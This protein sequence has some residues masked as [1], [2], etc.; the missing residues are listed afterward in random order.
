MRRGDFAEA[1][2]IGDRVQRDWLASG[3]SRTHWPR[4]LQPVWRGDALAGRRVLVRCYHGLGDTLQFIRFAR[5]LRA[6]A[7]HVTVWAQP[8]LMP[9]LAA[10]DG[11]DRLMALHDGV[12]E[13]D[14][15]VDIEIM[16]L[17]HALRVDLRSLAAGHPYIVA[18]AA[19]DVQ[20]EPGTLSV[21]L[22]WESGGW[23]P[24][25]SVPAEAMAE[26]A[27]LPGVRLLSLQLGPARADAGRL[28]A[29]DIGVDDIALTA[30]R[31]AALDVIVC[32]DTMVAHLAGAL[33]APV[34]LLLHADCDWRWMRG[35][36]DSPWYPSMRLFRQA[37]AGDWS[38]PLQAVAASL[39]EWARAK[40]R[41]GYDKRVPVFVG[42]AAPN[43]SHRSPS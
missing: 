10:V 3:E 28:G 32:V 17:A 42:R 12:V 11:I 23:D 30:A 34:L 22:V 27:G 24:R 7:A 20:A 1:W 8:Q 15:D 19:A 4:H 2:R 13:A 5:P 38:E 31:I 18:G 14:F 43:R 16:E 35:R 33:R 41:A 25:R 6:I 39:R 37:R 36:A 21:G 26:L 9:L 29:R 40:A